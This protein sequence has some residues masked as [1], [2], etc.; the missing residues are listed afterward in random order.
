MPTNPQ[1]TQCVNDSNSSSSSGLRCNMSRAA[2]M[3]YFFIITLIFTTMMGQQMA[4]GTNMGHTHMIQW[5]MP[6]KKPRDAVNDISW[7]QVSCS[8][9][10]MFIFLWFFYTRESCHVITLATTTPTPRM[11]S[12]GM[13]TGLN[14][15]GCQNPRLPHTISPTLSVVATRQGTN[16]VWVFFISFTC[17][18]YTN[19]LNY[20]LQMLCDAYRESTHA[21]LLPQTLA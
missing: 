3:F 6:K 16:A 17:F 2:G 4:Q 1:P 12:K 14:D 15:E 11:Y 19:I 21:N 18:I 20:W 7:P 13:G 8:F 10:F 5:G 9:I